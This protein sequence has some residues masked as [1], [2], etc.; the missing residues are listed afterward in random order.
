[1]LV[2]F[3]GGH[4]LTAPIAAGCRWQKRVVTRRWTIVPIAT[5]SD[6][7]GQLR[8]QLLRSDFRYHIAIKEFRGFLVSPRLLGER[9]PYICRGFRATGERQRPH[10]R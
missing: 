3:L 4:R 8:G 1:M 7:E 10:Y 9:H 5:G 2:T 6:R